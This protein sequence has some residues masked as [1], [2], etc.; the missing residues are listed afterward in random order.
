MVV[1]RTFIRSSIFIALIAVGS[2]GCSGKKIEDADPAELTKMAEEDIANDQFTLA[3]DKLKLVRNKYAY[4]KYAPLAQL[5]IADVYFLQESFGEAAPAYE[6]FV[7]LHPKHEKVP[8]AMFRIAE[9][10]FFDTPGNIA[11]DLT[12][13]KKAE[14]AY[15]EFLRKFPGDPEADNARKHLADTRTRL[16][17][18]ELYIANFYFK[19]DQYESAK[20]RYEKLLLLYPETTQATIAREKLAKTEVELKKASAHER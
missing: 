2:A 10:H 14:D 1:S 15:N 19:Q 11:R 7:D 8:Y 16:S 12:P 18:K 9:S 20:R 4:S 17:E 3:L 5:R 13:A 6:S